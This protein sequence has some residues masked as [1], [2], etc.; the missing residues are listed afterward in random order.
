MVAAPAMTWLLITTS[1]FGV[2]IMPVPSSSCWPVLAPPPKGDSDAGNGPVASID[3]TA[4]STLAMTDSFGVV[5]GVCLLDA[6]STVR[7]L[8]LLRGSVRGCRPSGAAGTSEQTRISG[9]S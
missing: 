7:V 4:G 6:G 8:H 1:P 9:G 3:T 2:M 5:H